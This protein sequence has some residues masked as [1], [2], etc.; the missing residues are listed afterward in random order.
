MRAGSIGRPVLDFVLKPVRS[1]VGAL[2]RDALEPLEDTERETLGAVEAIERAT[3]SLEHHVEVIES[4]AT[5]VGPLTESVD[6]LN[7]SVRALVEVLAPL[8]AAEHEVQRAEHGAE[9]VEHFLRFR[10]HQ[11]PAEPEETPPES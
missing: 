10:R 6:R 5:S 4:L 7:D 11:P 8:A 2:N 1:A 9:R 3:Q